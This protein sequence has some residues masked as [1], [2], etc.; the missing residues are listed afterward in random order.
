M[1]S[2]ALTKSRRSEAL[3]SR[4]AIEPTD[5][6]DGHSLREKHKLSEQLRSYYSKHLDPSEFPDPADLDALQAIEAA[7]RLFDDRL[8]KGFSAA[9][10][11]LESLNYPGVT[12]PKLTIATK[13]D[14]PTD[15]TT[16]PPCNTKL[17]PKSIGRPPCRQPEQYNGLGYQNLISMVFQLMSFRDAWMRVGKAGRESSGRQR[18]SSFRL[19]CI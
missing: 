3:A 1:A 6:Q 9:I 7:Q 18:R 2:F 5:G 14:R 16:M 13:C 17:S 19:P 15:S 12:D 8:E 11:E 4:G 10:R